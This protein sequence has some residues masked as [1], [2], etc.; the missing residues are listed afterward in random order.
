MN[1]GIPSRET[2]RDADPSFRL[3]EVTGKLSLEGNPLNDLQ[4][5]RP[6]VLLQMAEFLCCQIC[7]RPIA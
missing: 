3:D 4:M 5:I 1:E 2:T 6:A 7:E